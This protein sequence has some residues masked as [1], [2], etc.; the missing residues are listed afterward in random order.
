[1][2]TEK[3]KEAVANEAGEEPLMTTVRFTNRWGQEETVTLKPSFD[4]KPWCQAITA[5]GRQCFNPE[6]VTKGL[7]NHH[8]GYSR[9]S[10]S[11]KTLPE[12][13][14]VTASGISVLEVTQTKPSDEKEKPPT[15]EELERQAGWA[16]VELHNAEAEL[17][18][19]TEQY[20]GL[21]AEM[22]K[23]GWS[24]A[25]IDSALGRQST[26]DS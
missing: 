18:T 24:S 1:M 9:F 21:I 2:T 17:L 23:R 13:G 20:D 10:R 19:A 12:C 7:C 25:R 3:D 15:D 26:E 6:Q 16:A 8:A 4:G 5:R 14:F 11:I 22:T